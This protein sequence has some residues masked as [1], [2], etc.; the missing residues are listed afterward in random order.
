MISSLLLRM[1]EDGVVFLE[2]KAITNAKVTKLSPFI[3][4]PLPCLD[5][6]PYPELRRKKKKS[7]QVRGAALCPWTLQLEP[8]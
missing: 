4:T 6:P 8:G 1:T 2:C 7:K 5:S 3:A